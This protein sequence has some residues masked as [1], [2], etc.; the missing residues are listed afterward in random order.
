M[1][2]PPSYSKLPAPHYL[3]SPRVCCITLNEGD[4]LRLIGV[5]NELVPHVR[6]GIIR[7]WGKIQREQN[8]SGAHEFKMSGNPWWGYGDDHVPARR[9]IVEVV[10]TMARQG[11]NLVQSADVS[12]KENDKDSLFFETVDPNSIVGADLMQVDMFSVSFGSRDKLR[13]IDPPSL[14]VVAVVRQAINTQWRSGISREEESKGVAMFKLNGYPWYPQAEE[15]VYSRM[16][17]SQLLANLRALGY[18]LYTSVDISAGG[19]ES[20]DTETWIF[21]RVGNAWS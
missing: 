16:M 12:K 20:Q 13:V 5:P 7:S 8:Y 4:K 17:L 9:L 1:S 14:D 10:R 6:A 11:W 19:S 15:T 21:R 18:K 2:A 3:Q